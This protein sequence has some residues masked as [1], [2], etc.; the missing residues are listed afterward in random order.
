[1]TATQVLTMVALLL[2]GLTFFLY[3][4]ST[5]SSGLEQMAGGKLERTMKKVGANDFSGFFLGAGVTIAI[6]SSS[7]LTVMLVGMVNSGIMSFA[8][9]FGMIMGSHVGTTLTAWILTLSGVSGE[10]FLLTLLKPATF[11]PLLAFVGIAMLMFSKK[12]RRKN[13]AL[14][15]IGFAILMSGMTMMSSAVA[16]EEVRGNL[17]GLLTAFQSPALA[18]LASTLFT[19]I[20]QSSAATVAIV[21]ALAVTGMV[22]YRT[23]IPLIL[24]ANIGTCMTAL[25]SCIGTNKE[26]KR[27]V[28]MHIYTNA[29]G[30]VI[31]MLLMYPFMAFWPGLLDHKIG[32]IGVALVHSLFNIVNTIAFTPFKGLVLKLCR[33]TVPGTD[34]TQQ[35]I[36]LDERLFLT[37]PLAISECH[38]LTAEMAEYAR[39]ALLEALQLIDRYD[40]G[41]KQ[42]VTE[43]EDLT[44]KYEDKLGT[45]LVRLSHNELSAADSHRIGRLLHSIGDFERIGDHALNIAEAAAEIHDKKVI[46]SPDAQKELDTIE[47]AITEII[48]MTVDAFVNDDSELSSHI[49]PLEQVIDKLKDE[50]KARH[51][52]R[53]QDG[54]CTV[55]M[56]F[57]FSDLLTNYERISDHCSNVA[58]YTMQL[59]TAKLDAHKYLHTIRS[60]ENVSFAT[61]YDQYDKKYS[62]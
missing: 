28:A 53:L 26:A 8:D 41:S 62:I 52:N 33:K 32:I 7:A 50:M 51:I 30:G 35:T 36:F 20:I 25:I 23:A 15:F 58:V 10:S 18:L 13:F 9:T 6:Q 55:Q 60:D 59:D 21:Q 1:M 31:C 48:E 61:D 57:I 56:G 40:A 24:G 2:G 5:M 14:I 39:G 38:R 37:P 4:M 12:E 42:H 17:E 22:N 43:I 16:G 11:A 34:G 3:G 29:I 47:S 45:Y 44:D 27:V 19:G 46:F 54:K 49:E